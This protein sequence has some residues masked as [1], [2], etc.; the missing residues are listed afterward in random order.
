SAGVAPDNLLERF[1]VLFFLL[2]YLSLLGLSSLPLWRHERRLFL[3][4][5]AAGLY[6]HSPY[7]LAVAMFDLLLV[8]ALPPLA[9]TVLAYPL[10]GLNTSADGDWCLLWFAGVLVLTN[11]T[12]ALFAMGVGAS[13][14]PPS[15]SNLVGGLMV[16]TFAVFGRFL[17]NGSRIPV[18]WRWLSNVTPLGY[19][20]E[21]LLINEFSDPD[22]TRPYRI[23]GS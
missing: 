18:G 16:L 14:L 6:S 17:L 12:V 11:V 13:G 10:A 1:G 7:F 4:E 5:R 15:Q 9:L 8:R 22:G 20:F 3:H 21:A 19:A 2:L 23:E